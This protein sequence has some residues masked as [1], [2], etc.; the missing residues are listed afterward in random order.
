MKHLKQKK[1]NQLAYALK[2]TL[3]KKSWYECKQQPNSI[4][5]LKKTPVI[6]L[7]LSSISVDIVTEKYTT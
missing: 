5:Y 4:S 1:Q 7:L 2:Q 6:N 3:S